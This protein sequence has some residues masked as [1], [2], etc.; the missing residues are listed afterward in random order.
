MF[1]VCFLS[2]ILTVLMLF[3]FFI[4]IIIANTMSF[5]D[6]KKQEFIYCENVRGNVHPDYHNI[7]NEVCVK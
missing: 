7:Y 5:E 3:M 2:N 6:E 1:R 4:F